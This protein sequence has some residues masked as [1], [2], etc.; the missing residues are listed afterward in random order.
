MSLDIDTITFGKYKNKT[1]KDMLKDRNYCEWF[2]NELTM[3]DKYEYIYNRVCEYKPKYYF[4][5]YTDNLQNKD[6]ID[7]IYNIDFEKFIKEFEYFNLTPR[8]D[9]EIELSENDMK[10]YKFY[11][12]I[13]KDIKKKLIERYENG[14]DNPFDIKA[15]TNWLNIYEKET[16][17]NRE[18]FKSFIKENDL[19]NI[20]SIIET[21][22]KYGGIE[23]KGAKS[24]L[25]SKNNSI[26]QEQYW[27]NILK[28][29]YGEDIG[30]QFKYE[31]CF[32]DFINITK[33][34]IYECK[35]GLK[36]FNKIQYDKYILTLNKYNIIYI[37][38]YD[39]IIDIN[40]KKIYINTNENR[41]S[42]ES[43][44]NSNI[45]NNMRALIQKSKNNEFI[46]IIINF[47][48]ETIYN[49][50]NYI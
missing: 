18:C 23:Y 9:L 29:K 8:K 50:E 34:I 38:G 40:K 1:L 2:K 28:T 14:E 25:I 21:I 35:L 31:N 49:I 26:K 37:I 27:E 12:K 11:R 15:P 3:K 41:D 43:E 46:N 32:F 7:Y 10:S 48:I 6:N 22:K 20:T 5:P 36:D 47:D 13:L 19:D 17:L 16:G 30:V 39:T 42:L 4:I 45:I 24:F 33:N 44:N